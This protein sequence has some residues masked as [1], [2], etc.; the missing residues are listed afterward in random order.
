MN[1]NKRQKT[2]HKKSFKTIK[3]RTVPLKLS[4]HLYTF[5]S[6]SLTFKQTPK[7]DIELEENEF[8]FLLASAVQTVHGEFANQP[9][10][11]KFEPIDEYNYR[12]L[13]R[14]KTSHYTR[15]LT[16]LLLYGNWKGADC[17]FEII[18]TAQTPCFL[19]R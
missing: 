4:P 8:Q 3:R 13:I 16:S 17:K 18:K 1:N 11:L 7:R 10:I 9:D 14:F 6:I 19:S 5:S 15:T 12:S 2:E